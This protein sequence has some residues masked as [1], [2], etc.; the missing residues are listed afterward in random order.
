[1]AADPG[2]EPCG[3]CDDS[4]GIRVLIVDDDPLVRAALADRLSD[5][6]DLAVVGLCEDGS[7]VVDAVA[8][9]HPDVVCMDVS[10][11]VTNGLAATEAVRAADMGVRIIVLSGGSTTRGEA[12]A[13][14][15]DALVPKRAR[16]AGLLACVRALAVRGEACPYCL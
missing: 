12:G 3:S 7:E 11:R 14:G 5:E 6:E 9:L 13:V 10:M 2:F 8:R 15:A 1:M 4:A 16:P